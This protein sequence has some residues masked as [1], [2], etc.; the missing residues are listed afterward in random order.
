MGLFSKAVSKVKM[1]KGI[2]GKYRFEMQVDKEIAQFVELLSAGNKNVEV[3]GKTVK[4]N[5]DGDDTT[6]GQFIAFAKAAGVL[7]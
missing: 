1:V 7:K 5:V 4:F 6:A 3:R 2:G